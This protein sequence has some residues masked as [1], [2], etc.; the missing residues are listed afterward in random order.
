MPG[1]IQAGIGHGGCKFLNVRGWLCSCL[2]LSRT[3]AHRGDAMAEST[4]HSRARSLSLAHALSPYARS[5][6]LAHALSPYRE[7]QVC[8]KEKGNKRIPAWPPPYPLHE[9]C[10]HEL[11]FACKAPPRRAAAPG[12]EHQHAQV[13]R[14]EDGWTR[15]EG[16]EGEPG[17]AREREGERKRGGGGGGGGG[18]DGGGGEGDA[19]GG[20]EK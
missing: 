8:K 19:A 17:R 7:S 9:R 10:L 11:A 1:S 6:S 14:G 2:C 13:R 16:G 12:G 5:L 3:W 20:R 15:P 18:G 4:V